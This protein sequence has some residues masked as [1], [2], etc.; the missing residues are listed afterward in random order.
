MLFFII[1]KWTLSNHF[2]LG[3]EMKG[4]VLPQ[5]RS[6][7]L[8]IWAASCSNQAF[9]WSG[10]GW[11]STSPFNSSTSAHLT[12]LLKNKPNKPHTNKQTKIAWCMLAYFHTPAKGHTKASWKA[13]HFGLFSAWRCQQDSLLLTKFALPVCQENTAFFSLGSGCMIKHTLHNW[14]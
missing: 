3:W 14:T 4:E 1:L 12:H 7:L 2:R 10:T 5:K 6:Y 8:S 13:P 9:L 11:S